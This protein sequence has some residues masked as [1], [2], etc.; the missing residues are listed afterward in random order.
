[1]RLGTI[2]IDMLAARV[3]QWRKGKADPLQGDYS[4]ASPCEIMSLP[5]R[6]LEPI[7]IR[8]ATQNGF[9]CRFDTELAAFEQYEDHL[10]STIVDLV[11]GN[12][13]VVRSKYLCGA[14]GASSKVVRELDLPMKD[15]KGGGLS[16]NLLVEAD[17]VS[18]ARTIP[19][20]S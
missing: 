5:R 18:R 1:M 11:T 6:E 10:E 9:V 7:L 4:D 16:I 13:T 2:R 8:Y 20:H 17:L 15:R 12:Q 14:D 19:E 3:S